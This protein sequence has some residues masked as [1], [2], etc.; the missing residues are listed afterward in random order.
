VNE[1]RNWVHKNKKRNMTK[2]LADGEGREINE[3]RTRRNQ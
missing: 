3:R 1:G 2:M